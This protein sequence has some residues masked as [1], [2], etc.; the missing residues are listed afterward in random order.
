MN[1][2]ATETRN[3]TNKKEILMTIFF[4]FVIFDYMI[5]SSTAIT[6][7]LQQATVIGFRSLFNSSSSSLC[8]Q[9][10]DDRTRPFE[11]YSFAQTPHN[12][13]KR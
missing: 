3:K 10:F 5:S 9:L 11:L 4:T 8:H 1:I 6:T 12:L 7:K 13:A 2:S